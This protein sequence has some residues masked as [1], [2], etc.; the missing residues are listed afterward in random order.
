LQH[1]EDE[2]DADG[3]FENSTTELDFGGRMVCDEALEGGL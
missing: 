2:G 1:E 3:T